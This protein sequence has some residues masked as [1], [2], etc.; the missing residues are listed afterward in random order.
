MITNQAFY[1]IAALLTGAGIGSL[2]TYAILARH[3]ASQQALAEK[4]ENLANRIF[5]EKTSRFKQ[6]SETQLAG[7]LSP[8]RERLGEFQKKVDDSF[9]QQA[10]E[11]F[12]LKEQIERIV[13]SNQEI[14]KQAENLTN[15]LKGN[16]KIQGD[17]GEVILET[18]LTQSGLRRDIDYIVQGS[19][20]SLKSD[21][22][23]HQRP[24]ILVKLPDNKHII[25]DSK[26][27]LTD[28][29]RHFA[30]PDSG[31]IKNFLKSIRNHIN[32][33]AS[34]RYQDN[35][36]LGAPDFVLMFIP[37]EG[38][39]A[40]ALQQ[41]DSLHAYAWEKRI[42]LVCASTL[43]ATLKVVASLWRIDQQNKNTLEI[44]RQGGALYDEVAR[45]TED[46]EKLGTDLNRASGTYDKVFK[47][48]STG[49]GNLLGR[50]EKLKALGVKAEKTIPQNY[51][52]TTN[53]EAN[54][55]DSAA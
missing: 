18:I 3:I 29:E 32:D 50:S 6:D 25:I 53:I 48:L 28:Y 26:V 23:R 39:Y 41:D 24:D 30:E 9:G 34:K 21:D 45:L 1:M 55:D 36:T 2:T 52:D 49:R 5:D 27:S 14:T 4:F 13:L 46:M 38:A 22:G 47:R 16:S 8:L 51:F 31:H 10:K 43:F 20:L 37:I 35:E 33:L 54:I 44:A 11:Q 15:A 19:G 17:W 42:T 40:L 12:S 7:I